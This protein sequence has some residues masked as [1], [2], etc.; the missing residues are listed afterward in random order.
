MCHDADI[1]GPMMSTNSWMSPGTQP[2]C[3]EL[4]K[5]AARHAYQY[6]AFRKRKTSSPI[7]SMYG[8]RSHFAWRNAQ[9]TSNAISPTRC[10]Q[11][12]AAVKTRRA[13]A[14]RGVVHSKSPARGSP[15]A[16]HWRL[17]SSFSGPCS[18]PSRTPFLSSSFFSSRSCPR[19]VRFDGTP[20]SAHPYG[21]RDT[22]HR[23]GGVRSSSS[24]HT[25]FSAEFSAPCCSDRLIPRASNSAAHRPGGHVCAAD[26]LKHTERKC[27]CPPP[28]RRERATAATWR[29]V[30]NPCRL[31]RW[32]ESV[33]IDTCQPMITVVELEDLHAVSLH[34]LLDLLS[35][36]TCCRSM[37]APS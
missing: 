1:L 28:Q 17:T 37:G 33:L 9:E 6:R 3:Q 22:H 25:S 4:S 24:W 36:S 10:W 5:A 29:F 12:L 23:A 2:N 27:R 35:R 34:E 13:A 16:T 19:Q 20:P 26:A 15:A 31:V 21:W 7:C 8:R 30:R 18:A 11:C 14:K 32:C